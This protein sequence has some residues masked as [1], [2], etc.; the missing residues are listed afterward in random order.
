MR[1]LIRPALR[2]FWITAAV[3]IPANLLIMLAGQAANG[4]AITVDMQGQSMTVD[5]GPVIAASI[6]GPLLAA[7]G[8]LVIIRLLP[9]R[10]VFVFA[11]AGA[12]VTLLSLFGTSSATTPTGVA[13]LAMMHL[14]TGTV[15][16]VGNAVIHARAKDRAAVSA[17]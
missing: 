11:I 4:T 3:L 10:G 8:A 1:N 12:I 2:A 9:R 16:V 7:V 17:R 14:V 13:T 15:V 5:A 6:V